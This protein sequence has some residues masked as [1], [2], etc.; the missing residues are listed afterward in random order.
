[1]LVF[2]LEGKNG[3]GTSDGVR[4]CPAFYNYGKAFV[5][6]MNGNGRLTV[7][8]LSGTA[9]QKPPYDPYPL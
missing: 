8:N 7:P 2:N 4:F 1:M 3:N 5:V 6:G 9:K